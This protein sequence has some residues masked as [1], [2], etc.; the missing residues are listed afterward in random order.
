MAI[1]L[2]VTVRNSMADSITTAVGATG[3]IKLYSGTV[4]ADVA[5]TIGAAVLLGTLTCSTAFAP[6]S[7]AGVL[8]ANTITEDSFADA[9]GTASFFRVTTSAG[10]AVAQGTA[11]ASAT[12]LI[13]NTASIVINGP[14]RI[15]SLTITMGGA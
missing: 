9:T 3:L 11:G 12:D 7:A 15:S 1:Q 5:T 14:I 6:A 4:P 8:T 2:T 13:L 10:V